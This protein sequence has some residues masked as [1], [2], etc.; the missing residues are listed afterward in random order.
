MAAI[1]E[2]GRQHL[3]HA[4][5]GELPA[6]VRWALHVALDQVKVEAVVEAAVLVL[7]RELQAA[8]VASGLQHS[9]RPDV[10]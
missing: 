3:D 8:R 10:R 5:A 6:E 7:S 2:S 9:K 1:S 4:G